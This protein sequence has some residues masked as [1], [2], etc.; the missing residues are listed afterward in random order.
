MRKKFYVIYGI[1]VSTDVDA[2]VK[3]F[4]GNV[5]ID[6]TGDS[7]LFATLKVHLGMRWIDY[8]SGQGARMLFGLVSNQLHDAYLYPGKNSTCSFAK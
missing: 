2:A 3:S 8:M 1:A 7:A 6:V 5:V 4:S